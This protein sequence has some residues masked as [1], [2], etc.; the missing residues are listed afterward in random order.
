MIDAHDDDDDD[1]KMKK[2][3]RIIRIKTFQLGYARASL[4]SRCV[5]DV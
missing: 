2:R 4:D 5:L 1:E 3:I